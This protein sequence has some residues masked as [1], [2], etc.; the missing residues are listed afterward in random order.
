M[1]A[2]GDA[3]EAVEAVGVG[4]DDDDD[5]DDD[6]DEV[7]E[8]A[9]EDEAAAVN[10]EL[11]SDLRSSKRSSNANLGPRTGRSPVVDTLIACVVSQRAEP[12]CWLEQSDPHINKCQVILLETLHVNVQFPTLTMTYAVLGPN[13]WLLKPPKVTETV[14]F[15]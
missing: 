3:V 15:S 9:A 7:E 12:S 5:D 13:V 11:S 14:S 6:D 10:E 8:A 2:G 1:G 4:A